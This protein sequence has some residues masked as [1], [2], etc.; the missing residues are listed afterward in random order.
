MTE[1]STGEPGQLRGAPPD[2]SNRTSLPAVLTTGALF[3]ASVSLPLA[4]AQ[5][6]AA[7]APGRGSVVVKVTEQASND[8]LACRLTIV[9]KRGQLA[10][11]AADKAPWLAIRPGV[12]YTATGE[13]QFTLPHGSYTLYANRGL[14][15]SLAQSEIVVAN[16][17]VRIEFALTREVDTAGYVACDP[18]IHT[19]TFSRHGDST[20]EERMVTIAGEGIELAISSEHNH[21]ADYAPLQVPTRTTRQFTPVIGNEVTTAAGHF[22]AFPVDAGSPVAEFRSTDWSVLLAGMR[23]TP[24]VKVVMLNHPSNDHSNFIPTDPSRFHPATGESRDGRH[25]DFDAIETATSAAMQSDWMKPYRDWFL[26]LNRGHRM[27][28]MGSSDTHDVN[29]FILGQGRTYVASRATSAERIDVGEACENIRAG[30]ALV[31]L[32]LL[33][34]AWVDGRGV[35]ETVSLPAGSA[36]VRVRVQGPRWIDA[37]RIELYLNGELAVTQSIL[38][39]KDSALKFDGRIEL[40]S[41]AHDAW[42]VVIASGPGVRGHYWPTPRPYKPLRA[43]WESR[44]FGSTNPLWL[45]ADGDRQFS[46]AYAYARRIVSTHVQEPPVL[47]RELNKLDSAASAQAAS[48]LTQEGVDLNSVAWRRAFGTAEPQVRHAFAAFQHYKT[49]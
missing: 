1:Q 39:P 13:A 6:A 41:L 9:D 17:P 11:V 4:S 42:L 38:P 27:T 32:G 26:L 20:A 5:E 44:V 34:E 40:P 3:L 2:S 48:I 36:A 28:S 29:R 8:P 43:D 37:D 46:S 35:G 16:E 24:G 21:H 19:L 25:W 15:Y 18:H 45:D 23:K 30:C 22:N 49:K 31:S 14:E 33:V 47:I 12:I 7:P 10:P